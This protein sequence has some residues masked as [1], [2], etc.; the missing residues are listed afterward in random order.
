M[1]ASQKRAVMSRDGTKSMPLSV[2]HVNVYHLYAGG[3]AADNMGPGREV[4]YTSKPRLLPA[5]VPSTEVTLAA[6]S[7]VA[8]TKPLTFA[9]TPADQAVSKSAVE[10]DNDAGTKASFRGHSEE[11]S[12]ADAPFSIPAIRTAG[13]SNDLTSPSATEESIT[14]GSIAGQQ[15]LPTTTKVG[16]SVTIL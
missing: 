9:G 10:V 6:T 16:S 3:D 1:Y 13:Q 14:V 7:N 15:W 5:T 2:E 11:I 4:T 12:P 8:D